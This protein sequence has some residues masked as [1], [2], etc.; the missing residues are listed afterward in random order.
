M[1]NEISKYYNLLNN[2]VNTEETQELKESMYEAAIENINNSQ[3]FKGKL[4]E[5]YGVEATENL[6]MSK[7]ECYMNT[8]YVKTHIQIIVNLALQFLKHD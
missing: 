7:T 5:E 1:E 8:E 2:I 4:I 3:F 6:H